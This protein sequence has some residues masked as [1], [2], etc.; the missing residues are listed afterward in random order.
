LWRVAVPSSAFGWQVVSVFTHTNSYLMAVNLIPVAPFDGARAW[1]I[2]TVWNER[3]QKGVPYGTWR[4][5]SPD[6]QR[7]W[8]DGVHARAQKRS[9][10]TYRSSASPAHPSEEGSL[11]P[12][13]QRAIDELLRRTTGKVRRIDKRGP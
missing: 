9:R 5:A 13:N 3:G 6:A 10:A 11:E 12:E 8:F 7:A 2:F 1:R 4:G